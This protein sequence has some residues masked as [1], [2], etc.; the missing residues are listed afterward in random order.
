M[1]NLKE[2]II[3]SIKKYNRETGTQVDLNCIEDVSRLL[4]LGISQDVNEL[5]TNIELRSDMFGSDY[6]LQVEYYSKTIQ[7]TIIFDYNWDYSDKN[8]TEFA[9]SILETEME[10]R[11]FEKG[12]KSTL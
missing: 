10:I 9:E 1:K 4:A 7:K 5:N 6:W 11:A 12:L 3:K 8:I 2:K